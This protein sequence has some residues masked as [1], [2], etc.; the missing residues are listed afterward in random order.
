MQF[1]IKNKEHLEILSIMLVSMAHQDWPD[2][3]KCAVGKSKENLMQ[4]YKYY[5][6]KDFAAKMQEESGDDNFDYY[7]R[8]ANKIV[9]SIPE[10]LMKNIVEYI[11][12]EEF[13]DIAIH[14][15]TVNQLLNIQRTPKIHFVEALQTIVIWKDLNYNDA[16]FCKNFLLRR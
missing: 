4:T 8:C 1:T 15:V 13:S 11:N 12:D 6:I 3:T 5:L 7:Y 16:T 9:N 14:N 2:E 10:L